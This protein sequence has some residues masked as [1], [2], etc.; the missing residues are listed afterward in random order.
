[1]NRP[2]D[3][4]PE[5]G[6]S[7]R[8]PNKQ[9][10]HFPPTPT[11]VQPW[12]LK[13]HILKKR[14]PTLISNRGRP[15]LASRKGR[16]PQGHQ[17]KARNNISFE[18]FFPLLIT[19]SLFT[20]IHDNDTNSSSQSAF[21]LSQKFRTGDLGMWC[22]LLFT[23]LKTLTSIIWQTSIYDITIYSILTTYH[24]QISTPTSITSFNDQH[25]CQT[26]RCYFINFKWL[27]YRP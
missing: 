24:C 14:H 13:R 2:H 7:W 4:G 18:Y 23:K 26:S 1:M 5:F 10:Y 6:P 16:K 9:N 11:Q 8:K 3:V 15:L 22:S 12:R 21:L 19:A 17:A 25:E 27:I 20:L